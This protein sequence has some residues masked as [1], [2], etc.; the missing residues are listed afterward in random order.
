MMTSPVRWK[1]HRWCKRGIYFSNDS[2]ICCF[3]CWLTPFVR[4]WLR[5]SRCFLSSWETSQTLKRVSGN[6]LRPVFPS[7]LP[8]Q[9]FI[10][11]FSCLSLDTSVLPSLSSFD[12]LCPVSLSF[13]LYR[14]C[15]F[16]FLSVLTSILLC[17]GLFSSPLS[18]W[19][20]FPLLLS[21]FLSF[22]SLC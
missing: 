4:L 20:S 11:F 7:L 8:S 10:L 19:L 2:F 14:Q 13:L 18:F 15:L 1:P 16:P 12:V 17:F 3:I 21:F 6:C 22:L 5:P 9:V